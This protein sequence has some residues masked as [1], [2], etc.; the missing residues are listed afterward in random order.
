MKPRTNGVGGWD[1]KETEGDRERDG[2][3]DSDV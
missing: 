1:G 2:E 3:T